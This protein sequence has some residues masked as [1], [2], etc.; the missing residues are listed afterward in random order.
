[1][2][3]TVA[4]IDCGTNSIRVLILRSDGQQ[5]TE[6]AREVR[7][8]K[9]G[10]GVDATGAFHPD[11]LQRAFTIFD[12]F[13][14]LIQDHGVDRIRFVATSAARD[15]ANK[16]ELSDG[17]RA[18]LGVDVDVISGD[19][20][21]RLSSSGVVSGVTGER[22]LLVIDVGGGSTELV[23]LHDDGVAHATSL[24]VG[25]VRLR[26]RLMP[27]DPPPAD[28]QEQARRHVRE[29]LDASGVPFP[30]I[31]T[32]VGV[33]GTVTSMAASLLQLTEYSRD[34]VHGT[35]LNRGQVMELASRWLGQ[36]VETTLA[37]EP[38]MHP[39]RASVIAAGA[40]IV[41]EIS[42]RLPSGAIIVSE[43]DIL[44]GIALEML[45]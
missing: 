18:R 9:L 20:E 23:T 19:E 30:T 10:Q 41:D 15:A 38:V 21:A 40:L 7:L 2:S 24:N 36:P 39:L 1:M 35:V 14:G 25:A 22:P 28:Q 8:A 17:V 43:T 32:A 16:Q 27:G 33:A 29:L 26:E 13:A 3:H 34:A 45:R 12:E 44:D 6:L 4:A 37:G 11:A 31:R 5:T 42:E